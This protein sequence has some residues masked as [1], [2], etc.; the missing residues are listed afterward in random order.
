MRSRRGVP[1]PQ[2]PLSSSI[3]PNPPQLPRLSQ[4]RESRETQPGP[5]GAMLG[6]ASSGRPRAQYCLSA[7]GRRCSTQGRSTQAHSREPPGHLTSASH[8]EAGPGFSLSPP[9]PR[10]P[11]LPAASGLC[12]SLLCA[13]PSQPP[14]AVPGEGRGPAYPPLR[15]QALYCLAHSRFFP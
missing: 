13:V 8:P 15:T 12:S 14:G 9:Q 1:R 6:A 7:P 2:L 4:P 11:G 10:I 5:T 3:L